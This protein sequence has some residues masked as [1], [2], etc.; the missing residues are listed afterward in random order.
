MGPIPPIHLVSVVH[1]C[2]VAAFLGQLLCEAVAETYGS[3]RE[4]HPTGIRIHYL[5]DVFVEIPLMVGIL[6]SGVILAILVDE[7][8][9]LHIVLIA[10]GTLAVMACIFSFLLFVRTRKR[11][12]DRESVDHDTLVRIRNRFGVFTAAI[13]G[14]S[15][16]AA[17]IIGFKLAHERALVLFGG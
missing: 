6:V 3:P 17:L 1:L 5:I 10:C 2:F 14:P 13:I 9:A 11:L 7:L 12:L 4:R 16:L 15:L 8:S